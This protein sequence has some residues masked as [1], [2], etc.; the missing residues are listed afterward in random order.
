MYNVKPEKVTA[1]PEATKS[2]RRTEATDVIQL[3]FGLP[4]FLPS[5]ALH[6]VATGYRDFGNFHMAMELT[7]K[8]NSPYEIL[9]ILK[10][11]IQF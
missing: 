10:T 2:E 3:S 5:C 7:Q 4:L 6:T 1:S 11:S 9:N 8:K